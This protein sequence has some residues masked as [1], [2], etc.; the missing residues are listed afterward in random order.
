[1][2]EAQVEEMDLDEDPTFTYSKLLLLADDRTVPQE[3][4]DDI[5]PE[6][7][8]LVPEVNDSNKALSY[9]AYCLEN[10]KQ[11]IH[12]MLGEGS[13]AAKH[14]KYC[15]IPHS[16]A[17]E[18]LKQW[19]ESGGTVIPVCCVKRPSKSNGT[20][21]TNNAKLTQ[22]H[23]Q[24]LISLV[25]QNPCITV[26]MA[27]EQF[28]NM[29]QGLRISESSLRKHMKEKISLPLKNSSICAVHRDATRTIE[30]R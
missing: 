10:I 20:P 13:S 28:C 9:K 15:F 7:V 23:T 27:R 21:K 14:A 11:F 16:T 6:D 19:N 29:F 30:L 24:F 5:V 17:Y 12:L 26:N 22:K 2:S 4:G 25:D 8:P 1:M 3:M 18:I